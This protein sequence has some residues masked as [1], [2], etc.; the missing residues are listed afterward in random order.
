MRKKK[1]E[2][3]EVSK[4]DKDDDD[5]PL[6]EKIKMLKKEVYLVKVFLEQKKNQKLCPEM[7]AKLISL[8]EGLLTRGVREKHL[9]SRLMKQ[10]KREDK[11]IESSCCIINLI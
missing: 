9:W 6:F 11:K 7:L 8:K 2:G 3:N 4:K 10:T 1:E 5:L